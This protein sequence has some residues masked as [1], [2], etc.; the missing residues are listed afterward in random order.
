ML[1]PVI[2]LAPFC[3]GWLA[4]L[5]NAPQHMGLRD[6]VTDF[7]LCTRTIILS[8]PVRFLYWNMN[9]HIEHHMYA[10]VPCYKLRRLHE[11]IKHDL[12]A[13]PEGLWATWRELFAIQRK[14][15]ADPA[16]QYC[17]QLPPSPATA[18]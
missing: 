4:M 12:P 16:Y 8:F 10:A 7:R 13:C 5:C 1:I 3:G 6:N 14:Q 15:A 11:I 9:Y 2:T 17:V 18:S